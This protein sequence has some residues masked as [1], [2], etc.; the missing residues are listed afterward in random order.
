[1]NELITL[2]FL[3]LVCVILIYIIRRQRAELK[4]SLR[5]EIIMMSGVKFQLKSDYIRK[6]IK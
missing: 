4:R 5:N 1:M 3:A 6:S 2:S